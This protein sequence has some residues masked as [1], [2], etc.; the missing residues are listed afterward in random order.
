MKL[1]R[2]LVL[3]QC[4]HNLFGAK[5]LADLK[6]TLQRTQEGQ[7][8]DGQSYFYAGLVGQVRDQ[9]LLARL[10]DYDRRVMGYESRLARARGTFTFKYFQY[11]SLLYTEIYLDRLTD[12]PRELLLDLNKSLQHLKLKE[13]A[14][15][16]LPDFTPEDLRRLAFFM[17]TGSGKTLLLHVNLWQI[18]HYLEKGTHPEG[19]VLRT[20]KDRGFDSVLLITPN[21][22]LSQQH[23]VE[24]ERSGIDADFLVQDRSSRG[25][26]G[27]TVKIIEIHKLAEEPSKEG[28]SILL[29]ELGS[30]NLVFVDEGH[31]G[32]GSEA[33]TWK[34]RQKRLSANG[35]LLEY[36]AT[37]AQSIGSA[38]QKAQKDLLA[39]YGKSIL[40]DY[41]YRHFYEDG[42]GKDFHVLNLAKAGEDKAYDLLLAGLLS[43][44]Q[45]LHIYRQNL[46]SFR[47]YNLEKPLWIFLGSSVNAVYSREGQKRSDV[48]T[49]V[50]FLK[51][52]LEDS[53]WAISRL[54][55][56]LK[57]QSGF[58][59]QDTG[60]D[61]FTRHLTALRDNNP[62]DVY[63]QLAGDVF[64]GRG[65]LEIWELK[66]A[67][68]EIG[69]R[70]S[71]AEGKESP[72]FG[73]INIGDVSAF[74]KHLE[75]SLGIE[76]HEDRFHPSLF[77]EINRIGSPVTILIGS[78]KFIEGWS[79]WR[80]SAMGLLNMG[81]GEGPQVI[82]LFGRGVRLKGKKWTLKRSSFL[83]EEGPHPDG[84]PSLERLLIFGWNADYIQAFRK[85]LE[86]EDLGKELQ[87]NVRMQYKLW[88]NL[89]I[90]KPKKGYKVDSETWTLQKEKL[91]VRLDLTPKL[92]LVEGTS[93]GGGLLG[94]PAL[95][96]FGD[97]SIEAVLDLD[98]LYADL[99]EYKTRR[100]YQNTF[101]P[102]S[103]LLPILQGC[104]L[105][106]PSSDLKNPVFLQ[107]GASR[108]IRMYLDRFVAAKE[109]S[110][111]GGHLEPGYL[112]SVSES[113]I[114]YYSIRVSAGV[115]LNQL[116]N[117]LKKPSELYKNGERPLPRLHVERHLFSPLLLKPEDHKLEG[118][119]VRPP[120][121]RKEEADFL[122]DLQ[123][124]WR[125]HHDDDSYRHKEI[126]VLR[127][128]PRVGVGFFRRSGFYPDFIL[129]IIDKKDKTTQVQFLDPHGLHHGGLSGNRDKIE[130]LKELK[131]VS[132]EAPFKKKK[133]TMT[134]Y[135]LTRTKREQIPGAEDIE[136]GALEKDYQILRQEGK[137]YLKK[138]LNGP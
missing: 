126:Y 103:E 122:V 114:P 78:K 68:G 67:E 53:E 79:S 17:A 111:E 22:G 80:V 58:A 11:L 69:L 23:L 2:F 93:L 118:I 32:T 61:L 74:K 131:Q 136:W 8:A 15:Q 89:P 107:E 47:P 104:D 37:F 39:E 73:V 72:Y 138:I 85:M 18:M 6:Q 106:V 124:F 116:E 113:L 19:L 128:L 84:L 125:Q 41:S 108:V 110:A 38:S 127:N 82:Q 16:E 101:I 27:P 48:A 86:Q 63:R 43:F 52:F 14:I 25:L 49:V 133:I 119:S 112:S 26:F 95:V 115:L 55:A 57:G 120:G 20:D 75:E 135:L 64:Q 109:R 44:Y 99:V 90:P 121:L 66:G 3:N 98:A 87:V 9:E 105:Y 34:T 35:F 42:Y 36:S 65:G 51:R 33:Q 62:K 40:F 45:Q 130:A 21:E 97:E 71:G 13:V 83:P 91:P 46:D 134:G 132:L 96:D 94:K 88:K 92:A 28:V 56:I 10:C 29:E 30:S 100:G 123:E 137:G 81:K 12:D 31:K 129:W 77:A 54:A 24:F 1:D 4:F 50:V 7:G 5:N 70:I 117:L 59:D 102:R 60:E 76:V